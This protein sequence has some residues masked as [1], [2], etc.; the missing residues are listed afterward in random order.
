MTDILKLSGQE[1]PDLVIA[2]GKV[3]VVYLPVIR[4]KKP[5]TYLL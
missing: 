4:E 2:Q 5:D 3:D 1:N